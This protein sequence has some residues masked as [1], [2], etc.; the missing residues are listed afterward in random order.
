MGIVQCVALA[1]P[2]EPLEA[3][4]TMAV[5]YVTW[6][7]PYVYFIARDPH[8]QSAFKH[9]HVW[10]LKWDSQKQISQKTPEEKN[11]NE[12][13]LPSSNGLQ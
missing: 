11:G 5:I 8:T 12:A 3:E 1:S 10:S 7:F 6:G 2:E 9:N 4:D 13:T